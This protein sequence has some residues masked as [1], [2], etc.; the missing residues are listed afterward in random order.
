LLLFDIISKKFAVAVAVAAFD[1]LEIAV[2]VVAAVCNAFEFYAV[3]PNMI[4]HY[5]C[6]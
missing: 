3:Q 2:V 1:A 6:H 5:L 4:M